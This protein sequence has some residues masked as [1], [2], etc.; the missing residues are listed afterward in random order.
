MA[1][2][3]LGF[4]SWPVT[5][6]TFKKGSISRRVPNSSR[7]SGSAWLVLKAKS[8]STK[9]G[10]SDFIS[11]SALAAESAWRMAY[12]PERA[13]ESWVL[14]PSSSSTIKILSL[15]ISCEFQQKLRSF[16]RRR[17]KGQRDMKSSPLALSRFNPDSSSMLLH[18]FLGLKKANAQTGFFG[19]AEGLEKAGVQV[20][21][22]KTHSVVA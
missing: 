17:F 13:Q 5:M 2:R 14:I 18:D 9:A 4:S 20:L 15:S 22:T 3:A 8:K 6:M 11:K 21:R 7:P 12:S 16:Y 10:L 1:S 19:G